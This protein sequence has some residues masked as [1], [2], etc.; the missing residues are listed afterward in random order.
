[1][2]AA[3]ATI[4]MVVPENRTNNIW[5]WSWILNVTLILLSIDDL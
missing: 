5:S 2:Q 4:V 3:Q 1:M